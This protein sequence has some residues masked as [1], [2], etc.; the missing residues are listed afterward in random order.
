MRTTALCRFSDYY[1]LHEPF[2]RHFPHTIMTPFLF[3]WLIYFP[4]YGLSMLI[5]SY[6]NIR[7]LSRMIIISL[8]Y[9]FLSVRSVGVN[10]FRNS[11]YNHAGHYAKDGTL[12]PNIWS[13]VSSRTVHPL[14]NESLLS[15]VS[16]KKDIVPFSTIS[17]HA[18]YYMF[19]S[20]LQ[21][22]EM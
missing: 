9:L 20:S 6:S 2:H 16:T 4:I 13:P 15:V 1:W 18:I 10:R 21:D 7:S 8:L 11:I 14:I 22:Q 3:I 19:I 17:L 12:L 5:S